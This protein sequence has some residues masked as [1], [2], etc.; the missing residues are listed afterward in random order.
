MMVH[1]QPTFGN[2]QNIVNG[3]A[4]S[5]LAGNN[6]SPREASPHLPVPP[7]SKWS[8]FLAIQW[9]TKAADGD[10]RLIIRAGITN[11]NT[12]AMVQNAFASLNL[13][14]VTPYPGQDF[15]M[16]STNTPAQTTAFRGLLGTYHAAG[17]A[18]MLA[19]HRGTFGTKRIDRIRAW[20][21]EAFGTNTAI[22]GTS[23]NVGMIL[24]ISDVPEE[25]T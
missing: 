24:F 15:A 11:L 5:I 17:G 16:A 1:L 4:G 2:F 22:T 10:I 23:I 13:A 18:Y 8:D 25:T 19:G 6:L 7:L 20:G 9:A 21:M 14:T 12:K 3:A